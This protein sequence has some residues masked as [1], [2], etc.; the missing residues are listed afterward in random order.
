MT[1]DLRGIYVGLEDL[2]NIGTADAASGDFD[3]DFTVG[4]VG[5]GNFF[6]ADDALFAVDTGVHGFG[7]W[8]Q[9]GSGMKHGSGV[10][11]E[12]ATSCN[13]GGGLSFVAIDNLFM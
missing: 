13:A 7:D 8:P 3:Q 9:C 10:A 4:D 5:D 2:L 12:A 1:Q 6:D 11:H